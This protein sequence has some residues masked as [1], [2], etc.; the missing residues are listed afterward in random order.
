MTDENQV[1]V[2]SGASKDNVDDDLINLKQIL[3]RLAVRESEAV[4]PDKQQYVKCRYEVSQWALNPGNKE[5]GIKHAS[6]NDET[7]TESNENSGES[8]DKVKGRKN[9]KRK[10]AIKVNKDHYEQSSSEE[11]FRNSRRIKTK[12]VNQHRSLPKTEGEDA[13]DYVADSMLSE[14]QW[15]TIVSKLDQ[16]IVPGPGV[17]YIEMRHFLSSL[18]SLSCTV[19][20]SLKEE[21][22][23]G[24]ENWVTF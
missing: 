23:I 5:D 17:F 21:R 14:K 24:L 12:E 20:A 10:K 2:T 8:E 4:G 22:I 11:E 18:P 15:M 19:K 16:R 3:Q 9:K 13:E 6:T 1:A 7:I